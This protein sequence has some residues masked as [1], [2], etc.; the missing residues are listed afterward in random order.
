MYTT[1]KLMSAATNDTYL[2]KTLEELVEDYKKTN[3]QGIKNKVIAAMFCKVFPMILKIQ[4]KYYSLTNEQKVDHA[5]YH[6]IRSIKYYKNNNVKFSS[7]YYTHLT[8]QMKTLLSAENNLKKAAFQN[9][10]RN[11][12]EVLNTYTQN[13]PDKTIDY[14]EQYFLDNLR[15]S[16][17]LSSEE[18]EYCA[19]ILAGYTKTKEIANKLNFGERTKVRRVTNPL[20]IMD[21][22]KQQQ[23]DEKFAER[24]IRKIRNSLKEKMQ[25]LGMIAFE[26]N[27]LTNKVELVIKNKEKIFS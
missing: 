11:N 14:S 6:L 20:M 19:C 18:K 15:N 27:K 4:E 16:T 25:K 23:L 26:T 3:N 1:Y 21:M 7:F 24:K 10:I 5:I 17:Y 2:N 12:E 13:T 8:N 9:I 22:N